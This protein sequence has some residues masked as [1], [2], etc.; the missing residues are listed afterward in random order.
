MILHAMRRHQEIPEPELAAIARDNVPLL[1][2][3]LVLSIAL[4]GLAATMIMRLLVRLPWISYVGVAFLV[5]VAG[6]ML[7]DG[8]PP[9]AIL[10]GL[11]G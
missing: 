6:E 4:M 11:N 1:V 2:F 5:Y 10:L 8:W 3:G 7:W 9:V